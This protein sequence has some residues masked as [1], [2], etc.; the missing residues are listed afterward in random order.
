[1]RAES[2][3]GI[4][5]RTH[6][7]GESDK[8]VT[9]LTRDCGKLNG[10]ARGAKRSLRRFGGSLELFCHI[11]VDFRLRPTAELAFLERAAVV[12]PWRRLLSS[13]ERYAAASHVVEVADKMTAEREVGDRLYSVVIAALARLD[14]AEPGPLTLRLF[15]LAV[16][17]ACGYRCDFAACTRCRRA[18]TSPDARGYLREGGVVCASCAG[19][20]GQV[21]AVSP[22]ALAG[23]VRMQALASRAV[24]HE[25]SGRTMAAELFADEGATPRRAARSGTR[26]A[27]GGAVAPS[28]RAP[29]G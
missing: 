14:E 12:A 16:L 6:P 7:F 1:V 26:R 10:I 27:G 25:G 20:A 29:D 28:G 23:L 18:M 8:I 13:L 9:L 24:P 21:V 17:A 15:E 3:T 11:R 2:T 19:S 4:V 5:L 22:R